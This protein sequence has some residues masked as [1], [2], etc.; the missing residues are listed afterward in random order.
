MATM[1]AGIL[2]YRHSDTGIVVLL[3]HPG[4]PLWRNRDLGAWSIPK[5]NWTMVRSRKPQPDAN[6]QKNSVSKS[7]G[8]YCRLVKCVSA[9]E[10]W[11]RPLRWKALLM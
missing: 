2:M 7:P 10:N 3:V 1:S 6:S 8:R 11:F 9:P 4:G 5:E